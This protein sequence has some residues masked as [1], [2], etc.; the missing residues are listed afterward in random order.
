MKPR[1]QAAVRRNGELRDCKRHARKGSF[2]AEH[3]EAHE[4]SRVFVWKVLCWM[5]RPWW[6]GWL[7]WM[8]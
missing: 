2:C 8:A 7:R 4:R 5:E 1:C 6:L 3:F